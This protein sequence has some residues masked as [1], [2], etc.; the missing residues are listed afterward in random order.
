MIYCT[1]NA[2]NQELGWDSSTSTFPYI[3]NDYIQNT[4]VAGSYFSLFQLCPGGSTSVALQLIET[5]DSG[6]VITSTINYAYGTF[7]SGGV[8]Q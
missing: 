5:L 2:T 1:E 4:Y 6:E 3:A 8:L 7:R